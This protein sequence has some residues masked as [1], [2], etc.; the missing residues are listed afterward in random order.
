[1]ADFNQNAVSAPSID[2]LNNPVKASEKEQPVIKYIGGSFLKFIILDIITVG[3]YKF[4]WIYENWDAIKQA[5][6]RKIWPLWRAFFF[7][8]FV[9]SFFKKVYLSAKSQGYAKPLSYKI[10]AIG[11]IILAIS[12]PFFRAYMVDMTEQ[13]MEPALSVIL[14]GRLVFL[15]ME[16]LLWPILQAINFYRAKVSLTLEEILAEQ[17]ASVIPFFYISPIRFITL[18]LLIPYFYVVYWSYKNWQAIKRAEQSKIWPFW[19]AIFSIFFINVLFRKIYLAAK[20]QGYQLKYAYLGLA[21]IY[22][23]LFYFLA[24][25]S[26]YLSPFLSDNWGGAFNVTLLAA[27]LWIPCACLW[28]MQKAINFYNA[29]SIPNYKPRKEFTFGEVILLILGVLLYILVILVNPVRLLRN[30]TLKTSNSLA[31]SVTNWKNFKAP[32]GE[33]EASFPKEPKHEQEDLLP[34]TELTAKLHTYGCKASNGV[35]YAIS[36]IIYPADRPI[37]AI[38]LEEWVDELV[39]STSG[40]ELVSSEVTSLDQYPAIDFLIKNGTARLQGRVFVVGQTHYLLMA[41]YLT[42]NYNKEHYNYFI[43]SF[44]LVT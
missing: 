8:F 42:I 3:F 17:K 28:P 11:Y 6:K 12:W 37:S 34:D 26:F 10:L 35:L 15:S 39:N 1:M 14:Y 43:N 44:K 4:Y 25:L 9:Y 19:R 16:L 21:A 22:G 23:G 13:A 36:Q 40:N 20:S 41:S 7:L 31:L 30:I 29:R 38:S 32:T 2:L 5:E 24:I 33:F 18:N 27:W